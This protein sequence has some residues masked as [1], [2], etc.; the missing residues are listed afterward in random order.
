M[1]CSETP[2]IT[3]IF[4][5]FSVVFPKSPKIQDLFLNT[6]IKHKCL[7]TQLVSIYR[8]RACTKPTY[9][10]LCWTQTL[11]IQTQCPKCLENTFKPL[12]TTICNTLESG[13]APRKKLLCFYYQHT[14]GLNKPDISKHSMLKFGIFILCLHITEWWAIQ[15]RKR[16]KSSRKVIFKIK[17]LY[18]WCCWSKG[19][20]NHIKLILFLSTND[21]SLGHW[22]WIN[23]WLGGADSI[24]LRCSLI[25]RTAFHQG[26]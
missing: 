23:D 14:S 18:C 17:K 16:E 2:A 19:A 24:N 22:L 7:W 15:G 1:V 10:I 26:H 21:Q 3:G 11:L 5:K 13:S 8:C 12:R 25:P 4:L 9:L 6:A 20:P